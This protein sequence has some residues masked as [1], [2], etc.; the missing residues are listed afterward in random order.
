MAN[1]AAS[2]NSPYYDTKAG[3]G[4]KAVLNHFRYQASNQQ[5]HRLQ[6]CNPRL[7]G[8]H[9]QT[10]GLRVIELSNQGCGQ[11]GDMPKLEVTDPVEADKNRAESQLNR[12][13][14]VENTQAVQQ[15]V[16]KPAG[17]RR[18]RKANVGSRSSRVKRARDIFDV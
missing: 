10:C 14:A 13:T 2:S 17:I 16:Q 8:R 5:L 12:E 18:A 7:N 11:S 15:Q 3:I 9:K 1:A 6:P 4:F